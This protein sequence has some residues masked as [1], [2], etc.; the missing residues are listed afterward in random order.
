MGRLRN[1]VSNGRIIPPLLMSCDC[2]VLTAGLYVMIDRD[3]ERAS[4][5]HIAGSMH[6]C[7]G[8][9][10]ET[11]P[12]LVEEVKNK[13]TVVFHCSLSQV[14]FLSLIAMT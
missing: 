2:G 13:E 11:L 12:K 3:G 1:E 8:S 7:S 9:F 5:G 10:E 6:F 14:S 4:D